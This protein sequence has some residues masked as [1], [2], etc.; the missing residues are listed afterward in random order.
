MH[1]ETTTF[2]RAIHLALFIAGGV[3]FAVAA[4]ALLERVAGGSQRAIRFAYVIGAA[5]V[6]GALALVEALFHV[7]R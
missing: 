7:L 1:I 3:A 2:E 4:L 6:F 5:G